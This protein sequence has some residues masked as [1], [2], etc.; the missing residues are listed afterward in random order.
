MSTPILGTAF[1]MN[2]SANKAKKLI[3]VLGMHR[4]GTSAVTRG[5][6]VAGV[7]LGERLMP[8]SEGNNDKGF[9]EDLDFN[10]LN[11]EI[12]KSLNTDW[13]HFAS[14]TEAD[15]QLLKDK[16]FFLKASE[17]IQN[18]LTQNLVYGLKDPRISK[19]MPFWR[20]VFIHNEIDV[21]YVIAIRNPL[22]VV[23]SL[24]QRDNFPPEKSFLLWLGHVMCSLIESTAQ[25]RMIVDYDL[26]MR[27]PEAQLRRIANFLEQPLDQHEL[28]LYTSFYLDKDLQHTLF[29]ANDLIKEESCPPLVKGIYSVLMDVAADNL[30]ISEPAFNQKIEI[31]EDR[32]K[33][34]ETSLNLLDIYADRI[35]NAK[36]T[37]HSLNLQTLRL[38]QIMVERDAHI[39]NLDQVITNKDVHISN[40][41]QVITN[42]DVHISNLDQV[43]TNRNDEISN[44]H[45]LVAQ[46]EED[47]KNKQLELD[48]ILASHSWRF[49]KPLRIMSSRVRVIIRLVTRYK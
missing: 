2:S 18:K 24:M 25:K 31:W 21:R 8:A 33:E 28:D 7:S 41:D 19:L 38:S 27:F 22:S 5:L 11:I 3:L 13:H 34:I 20:Q 36:E 12:L 23:K 32:F 48:S 39:S 35:E 6:I 14:I 16:G 4:S 26:L 45:N 15:V 40:L 44:L 17:L 49:T 46:K 1:Q 29:S 43:I 10:T 30:D 47:V 37:I 9:W 42:K